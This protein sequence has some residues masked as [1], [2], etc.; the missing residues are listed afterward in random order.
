MP[1]S[2]VVTVML[3]PMLVELLILIL[4]HINEVPF[5]FP[6]METVLLANASFVV[7]SIILNVKFPSP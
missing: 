5:L 7:E 1:S 4:V 3:A 2:F 6:E